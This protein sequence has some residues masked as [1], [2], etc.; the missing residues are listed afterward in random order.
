MNY[1]CVNRYRLQTSVVT[2]R[3]KTCHPGC[4]CY[5]G[6][7][8]ITNKHHIHLCTN[9]VLYKYHNIN[10]IGRYTVTTQIYLMCCNL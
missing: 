8:R 3:H 9:T 7:N 5:P 4:T 6:H 10:C 2:E 1:S